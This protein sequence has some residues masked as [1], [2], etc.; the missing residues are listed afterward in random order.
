MPAAAHYPVRRIRS[1]DP[2][3]PRRRRR[4]RYRCGPALTPAGNPLPAMLLDYAGGSGQP[5]DAA[6]PL[7]QN[8][9]SIEPKVVLDTEITSDARTFDPPQFPRRCT[10]GPSPRRPRSPRPRRYPSTITVLSARASARL[11]ALPNISEWVCRRK[12]AP[13]RRLWLQSARSGWP[14]K[15]LTAAIGTA[16]AQLCGAGFA[17]RALVTTDQRSGQGGWQS[18]LAPFALR[19]H[20]QHIASLI[21]TSQRMYGGRLSVSKTK[22]GG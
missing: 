16:M 11:T 14:G 18:C 9:S 3:P 22:F 15:E 21:I 10:Q 4:P 6:L 17:P 7:R 12:A 19:L 1:F 2:G 13:G 8:V 5:T 20:F